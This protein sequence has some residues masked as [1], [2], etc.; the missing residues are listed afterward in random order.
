MWNGMEWTLTLR[1]DDVEDEETLVLMLV[2]SSGAGGPAR[3]EES[4]FMTAARA[5]R[6]RNSAGG[7]PIDRLGLQLR[8]GGLIG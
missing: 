5:G 3:L 4:L 2:R 7:I 8:L 6:P 1:F